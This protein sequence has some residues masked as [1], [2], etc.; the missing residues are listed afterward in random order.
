MSQLAAFKWEKLTGSHSNLSLAWFPFYQEL[1]LRKP[2]HSSSQ[3]L[4]YRD[5]I[6]IWHEEKRKSWLADIA[7]QQFRT[8]QM[9]QVPWQRTSMGKWWIYQELV[10][11]YSIETS[12]WLKTEFWL[13]VSWSLHLL[14]FLSFPFL[15][16]LL[17]SSTT[18]PS[19]R[20]PWHTEIV[21]KKQAKW[22]LQYV[23]SAKAGTD[24]PSTVP[25][26]ISQRRRWLNGW[27]PILGSTETR[28]MEKWKGRGSWW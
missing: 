12:S 16:F 23:K 15:M 10:L 13:S 19:P 4:S 6:L 24:V 20:H 27:V 3:S 9:E 5:I 8:M 28:A 21:T 26:F 2:I 22:R 11:P 25:E 18:W 17:S 7:T 14:V 1:S